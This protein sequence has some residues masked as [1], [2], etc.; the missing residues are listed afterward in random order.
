MEN[1]ETSCQRKNNND[2]GVSAGQ[3]PKGR[4]SRELP[5]RGTPLETGQRKSHVFVFYIVHEH[6]AKLAKTDNKNM[7]Y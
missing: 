6:L 7:K 1:D 2:F 4:A 3:F 5:E